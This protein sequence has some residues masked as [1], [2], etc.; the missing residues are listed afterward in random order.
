MSRRPVSKLMRIRIFDRAQGVCHLCGVKIAVGEAWE[1]DHVKALWCGGEDDERNM[2]PAHVDCHATKS[3]GDAAPKA[4]A[5]RQRA[6]HIGATHP[7]AKKIESRGFA[8]F[9]RPSKIAAERIE[10][11]NLPPRGLYGEDDV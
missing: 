5:D 4:K 3:R 6:N 11:I 1:A 2:A 9:A 8:R 10:K 7:P